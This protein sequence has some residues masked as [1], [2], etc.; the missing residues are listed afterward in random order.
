MLVL[1]YEALENYERCIEMLG[2]LIEIFRDKLITEKTE[3]EL[4]E[5]IFQKGRCYERMKNYKQALL[6]YGEATTLNIEKSKLYLR[7]A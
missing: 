6:T 2:I 4:F 3:E 5:S 7:I 1:N